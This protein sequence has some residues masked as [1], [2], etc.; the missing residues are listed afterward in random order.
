MNDNLPAAGPEPRSMAPGGLLPVR[1]GGWRVD[2]ALDE[3][4]S[5][6]I[7]VKLEPRNMRLLLYLAAH[8]GRVVGLDELL[9]EVWPNLVVTPQSVYNAVAQLRV[10][11]GDS[12]ESPL[13]IATVSRK[14]YRLV[15][16][17]EFTSPPEG[18][19]VAPIAPPVASAP[20]TPAALDSG[21]APEG[22]VLPGS[23]GRGW[24][25]SNM[26]WLGVA[27]LLAAAVVAY[28]VL[29]RMRSPAAPLATHS[30]GR[31]TVSE[32]PSIAVLPLLDLSEA[33]DQEYLSDGLAEE[34]TH[35]LSQVPGLRVASRTSTFAFK[36]RGND[37][38]A[39]AKRLHVSHVLEGSVRKS[40]DHLRITL[41]LIRTDTAFHVWSK[42]YDSQGAELFRLQDEIASD[43][44]RAIDGSLFIASS[45]PRPEP[46]PDAY[47]LLLQ[48]RYYGRRNT[49]ADR[50]RSIAL[51]E[52]AV[53]V[54]PTYALAWA[55]LAQ[56]YGVQASAEW[57]PPEIG[58]DRSRRAAQHAIALD[59][60]L[61]D[62]HAAYGYVLESFDWNWPAAQAEYARASELDP[63]SVRALNLNGHLAVTLG[64]LD[65]AQKFFQLASERDPLSPA[66]LISLTLIF[67][68]QGRYDEA[69]VV[70]RQAEALGQPGMHAA[71]CEILLLEHKAQAA[72]AEVEQ[73]VNERWRLSILP[74]VYDA[75]G[76][77]PDADRALAAL[78]DK[79]SRFPYRI[80]MVYANRGST[81]E[82]FEWLERARQAR[83]FDIMW[84]KT[85]P[86]LQSLHTDPRFVALLKR[87][88]LPP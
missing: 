76:R 25:R 31:A 74:R 54:D 22:K 47:S 36:G 62:G 65:Q 46:N 21:M 53:A 19:E 87:M 12:T 29:G 26:P 1:I 10:S 6:N 79:Y 9:R 39:I 2:P 66:P 11:L 72:L 81:D 23:P 71:L 30:A 7:V 40:A 27:V 64:Q 60:L 38:D 33:H 16:P 83:D 15:A 78:I 51:Y 69:A 24:F 13:Y 63:S 80:S 59:P 88:A 82:A 50:A 84:I 37:I 67:I 68:R 42:T 20:A 18:L 70:A 49:Q 17:V 52:S 55:W 85:E 8:A 41:Q 14:G 57:I 43:V 3:I 32:G 45:S 73:E 75:L 44:V 35:V 34:L 61:A 86:E 28:V 77:R 56:G 5:G 4:S 48:G 58:Y